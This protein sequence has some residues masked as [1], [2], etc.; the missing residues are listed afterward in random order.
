M[1]DL[2]QL[3]PAELIRLLNSTPAGEVLAPAAIHRHRAQAGLRIGDQR[4]VNLLRY[5]AWLFDSRARSTEVFSATLQELATRLGLNVRSVE[6]Y[7]QQGMPGTNGRWPLV[8]AAA[9]ILARKGESDGAESQLETEALRRAKIENEIRE[10]R[11]HEKRGAMLSREQAR[12]E[13]VAFVRAV[14]GLLDGLAAE[15][16]LEVAGRN[17][18]DAQEIIA[19]GVRRVRSELAARMDGEER[20]Q[21]TEGSREQDVV[22]ETNTAFADPSAVGDRPPGA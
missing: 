9:W 7:S 14:I 11:L 5:A 22:A 10:L 20:D 3:K 15:L 18:G 12:H 17:L 21:G 2:R 13:T 19:R 4:T 1:S 6:R 8:A 16:P